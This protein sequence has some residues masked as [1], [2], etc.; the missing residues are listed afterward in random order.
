MDMKKRKTQSG[1]SLIEL[2]IVLG[3]LSIIT[4]AIFEQINQAQQRSAAEQNK[5]DLMQESREFVDQMTRDLRDAGYPNRRNYA[6]GQL[7]DGSIPDVQSQMAAAGVVKVDTG[8]IRFESTD[9]TVWPDDDSVPAALKGTPKVWTVRYYLDQSCPSPPCLT[10]AQTAKVQGDPVLGQSYTPYVQVQ[11][12]VNDQTTEPIFSAYKVDGTPVTLPVDISNGDATASIGTI[13]VYL[14]V[15]SQFA[16]PKT[17]EKPILTFVSTVR[18]P[19]CTMAY[20]SQGQ[21][22]N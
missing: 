18:L 22:C 19:N 15:R 9:G 3:L 20:S 16:D 11:N 2:L 14:K 8:E 13:K 1:F 12:V 5:T 4:G 21:S 6:A 17:G 10:R 7:T